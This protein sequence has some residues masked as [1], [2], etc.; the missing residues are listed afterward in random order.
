MTERRDGGIIGFGRRH[1]GVMLVALPCLVLLL[2][3]G[4]V[5]SPRTPSSPAPGDGSETGLVPVADDRPAPDF[6]LPLL[7][8]AG[9]LSLRSLRGHVVVVN[10]WASWCR[11][12]AQEVPAMESLF[13]HY[14]HAGVDFVGIDHGDRRASALAFAENHGMGY[15][16]VVDHDGEVLGAYGAVGLPTTYVI[17]RAGRIRYEA[18]GSVDVAAL[19]RSVDLVRAG[20]A[21]PA[22]GRAGAAVR[23]TDLGGRAAPGFTL[24]DQFGRRTTLSDLRGRPVLL[25]F[26]DS[27]CTDV[28]SLTAELLQRTVGLL[29]KPPGQVRLLAVNA[30]PRHFTVADVHSWSVQHGMLHR[31]RYV[32]GQPAQLRDIWASYGVGSRF[33]HG[34]LEHQ[35]VVYLLDAGLREQALLAVS[36]LRTSV[37]AEAAAL[38]GAIRR[39]PAHGT[40]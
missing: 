26:V 16:S 13:R 32:T 23:L 2:V 14:Q 15:P 37:A 19:R 5:W 39:L 28:C 20:R 3:V 31:W 24:I 27:R 6:D 25:T 7:S 34:G 33:E 1:P 10:F 30:N 40:R 11:A 18:I 36:S 35:A 17:N 8:G 38:A 29:G 12:C 9:S 22:A 21:A 4:L